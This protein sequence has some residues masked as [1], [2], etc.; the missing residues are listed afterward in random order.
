MT[1]PY[2]VRNSGGS[3]TVS[4]S[5][6][7]DVVRR[8]VER[9]DGARLHR[10]RRGLVI[11]LAEE[12][13]RVRLEVTARLGVVLPALARDVQESVADALRTMCGIE[14]AA[15]DVSIEDVQE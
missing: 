7:A 13:A 1:A 4:A 15:V 2:V 12:P 3:I 10:P 14:V 11:E 8:A 6:Q 5:A 9:V